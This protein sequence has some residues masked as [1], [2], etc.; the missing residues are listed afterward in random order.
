MPHAS[1]TTV[2]RIEFPLE[3]IGHR[4]STAKIRVAGDSFRHLRLAALQRNGDA[5]NTLD[6]FRR[7]AAQYPTDEPFQRANVTNTDAVVLCPIARPEDVRS[8]PDVVL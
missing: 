2:A 6:F 8:S 3:N 5:S 7:I 1:K 4:R